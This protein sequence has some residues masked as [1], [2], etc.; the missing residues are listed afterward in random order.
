MDGKVITAETHVYAKC[1]RII[2]AGSYAM[3]L[4]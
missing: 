3:Y 4:E 1:G 2:P